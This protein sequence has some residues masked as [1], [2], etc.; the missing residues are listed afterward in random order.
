MSTWQ[1]AQ[2]YQIQKT[3]DVVV[4]HRHA[5]IA[6]KLDRRQ[7]SFPFSNDDRVPQNILLSIAKNVILRSKRIFLTVGNADLGFYKNLESRSP[8]YMYVRANSVSSLTWTPISF[9][10]CWI[11][12]CL[13]GYV[14]LVFLSS[15]FLTTCNCPSESFYAFL[16]TRRFQ[17]AHWQIIA[18]SCDFHSCTEG[19]DE[20]AH[21]QYRKGLL[22]QYRHKVETH[23]VS[24]IG[25]LSA[26]WRCRRRLRPLAPLDGC[27]TMYEGFLY[28]YQN[29]GFVRMSTRGLYM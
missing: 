10:V 2:V 28:E 5:T 23:P 9:F 26:Y 11:Y 27:A 3:G 25:P 24:K 4:S 1:N 13:L 20:L 22:Q 17:W 14:A 19:S 16:E 7:Q 21:M 12:Y 29:C 15:F 8:G 18:S 6:F